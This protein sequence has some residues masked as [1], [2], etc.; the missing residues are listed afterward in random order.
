MTKSWRFLYLEDQPEDVELVR[1]RLAREYLPAE[2]VWVNTRSGF[3]SALRDAWNFDLLLVDHALP[4]IGGDEALER[5]R[6]LAPHLP[7][8]F[9]AGSLGEEKAV[10]CL[11]RGATDYVLK[12]N[13][14]RLVPV[15][16]RAL[17]EAR[18]AGARREAE[19]ASAR[20]AA[21]LRATLETTSEGILVVDLA[22]RVSAYNRKF[23]S[24]CGIP[25][26][27]MAPM[28]LDQVIQHLTSHFQ[29]PAALL[30]EA[31]LL[32]S[33]PE[34]ESAGLLR[35][36]GGHVLEQV[37]RPQKV[38]EQTVGRVLSLREAPARTLPGELLEAINGSRH[39]LAEAA[40]AAR[41]VPWLLTDDLLV[42]PDSGAAVLGAAP[43]DLAALAGLLHPEDAD[44]L[45]QALEGGQN[46]SFQAR[47]RQADGG[48]R[49]IR[50][51]VDRSPNGYRGV[52]MDIS[53]QVRLQ[54]RGAQR[55]RRE[56][57]REMA[58]K[59]A[60]KLLEHLETADR[61]LRPLEGQAHLTPAL[62]LGFQALDQARQFLEQL[63]AFAHLGR[64]AKVL[65][66]PDAFLDRIL[67]AARA[68]A[69]PGIHLECEPAPGLPELA[70]DPLQIEQALAALLAN[71]RQ[72]LLGNGTIHLA[73]G[74]LKPRPHRPG[75][76]PGPARPRLFLE[77]RDA[78]PGIPKG[79]QK[80]VF[81]P[82]FSTALDQGRFGL[83]LTLVE[84]IALAHD[85]SVQ[86]ES[87]PGQGTRVR[88]LL[89]V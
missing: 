69:G 33:R 44:L 8:I 24:L 53:E 11:R 58:R 28:E 57:A 17:E 49:W 65:V 62:T 20:V 55:R 63:R 34:K 37:G 1:E 79:L 23:L 46:V 21:L 52:L 74:L 84:D 14:A 15:I 45:R 88:I 40:Q 19:A 67:P 42:L 75:S 27:V 13:L 73:A 78:G 26:Y 81:E 56:G 31:R 61:S 36:N 59:V 68:A 83:G 86:L 85:G 72:A 80:Q 10:E 22:G 16:R 38:G 43:K 60:G 9:L 50:W 7:F 76:L 51:I 25:E 87:A 4:D 39:G 41:V 71:A 70:L 47:V 30:E 6:E 32:R 18:Q 64:P 12:T 29:D 54:D 66:Q 89:P 2:L 35:V 48:W 5:A 82:F 3:L 77:V